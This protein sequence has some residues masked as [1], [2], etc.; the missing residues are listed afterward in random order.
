[1]HA[2]EKIP[3]THRPVP[4]CRLPTAASPKDPQ[5]EPEDLKGAQFRSPAILAPLSAR[6]P[7][8]GSIAGACTERLPS[9][10]APVGAK[11]FF[12]GVRSFFRR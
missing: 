12:L 9:G 7:H 5:R 10:V 8:H 2:R 1:M 11:A 3:R 6:P 4:T